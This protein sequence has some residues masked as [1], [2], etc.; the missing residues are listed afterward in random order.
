MIDI[1]VSIVS[2]TF[3][4]LESVQRMIESARRAALFL[5]IEFVIVDG[6]S[7]DGTLDYLKSQ[8]DVVLIEHGEL[9]GAI[10]AF[11]EGAT[12]SRGRFT[13]L[14][15]DDIE[16]H[17]DSIFKAFI[18]LEDHPTC[19]AVAFQD[20]RPAVAGGSTQYKAQMI[21][22]I[23]PDGAAQSVVYA[24]VG[25][26]RKWLGEL[27]GW[28]GWKDECMSEARTYGGDSWLSSKVW[29]LGY[30]VDIVAGVIVHD[31]IVKDALREYN[32]QF[33]DSAY[34]KCYPRGP[35][36]SAAPQ[37]ENPDTEQ[38]R[39]LYLP[40]YEPNVP[41]QKKTKMGLRK[42]LD[43]VALVWEID[44]LNEPFNLPHAVELFQ[45]NILFTQLHDARSISASLLQQC[46]NLNPNMLIINWNGDARG[47]TDDSYLSLLQQVDLQL[48]VNAAALATYKRYSI[49]AAY[50]QIGLEGY[51][52]PLPRV[53]KHDIVFLG[54]C[55]NEAR[56]SL[57]T[58]LR[59]T[60]DEVG[61]YGLNWLM[62]DGNCLYDFAVG[63]ALYQNATIAISDTFRDGKT[64]IDGFVSNRLFQALEAGA[65]VLQE[66]CPG[67]DKWTGLKAG[68]HY[69]EWQN[70]DHLLE[71]IEIWNKPEVKKNRNKIAKAGQRFIKK[72]YNFDALLDKLFEDIIPGLRGDYASA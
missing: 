53:P 32:R 24:Q 50:W 40:I 63:A 58:V 8:P 52:Q 56:R 5:P 70:Y 41:I 28:W 3:N 34:Y 17:I 67:L 42:A 68:V 61:L 9:R 35:K 11:S 1:L 72:N 26:F 47:L 19:G 16:F 37:I 23:T 43:K 33:I 14:A 31:Y 69:I 44:Y 59:S 65:F 45:P 18:Y 20:N 46:R 4:R 49:H 39:I 62:P 48:V 57:E 66:H 13:L 27:C 55:Y 25:L 15:N 30:S 7:T 38:L 29:E 60:G 10:N 21:P 36:V 71:L 54:N 22:A 2:G 64:D 12:V 6:G 51:A